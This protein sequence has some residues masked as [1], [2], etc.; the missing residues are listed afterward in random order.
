MHSCHRRNPEPVSG[1]PAAAAA[2]FGISPRRL[3]RLVLHGVVPSYVT[4]GSSRRV[5]FFAEI[6]RLIRDGVVTAPPDGEESS[7]S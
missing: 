2:R 6:E 7:D 3:R 4:P 1:S 5:V